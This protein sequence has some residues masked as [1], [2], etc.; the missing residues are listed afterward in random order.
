ML[1][2]WVQLL[3]TMAELKTPHEGLV[4]ALHR[5][6]SLDFLKSH[7]HS[8]WLY[9]CLGTQVVVMTMRMM[10]SWWWWLWRWWWPRSWYSVQR[11]YSD[12][13]HGLFTWH[14]GYC[15]VI[16]TYIRESSRNHVGWFSII[17]WSLSEWWSWFSH[18]ECESNPESTALSAGLLHTAV[19]ICS[20]AHMVQSNRKGK[21]QWET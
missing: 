7:H 4:G 8:D 1:H 20:P 9:W 15:H 17:I 5:H 14:R 13:S 10:T 12:R 18:D 11:S 16:I 19:G 2:G 6:V 3:Q 21:Q